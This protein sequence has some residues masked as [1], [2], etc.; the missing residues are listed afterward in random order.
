MSLEI[1]KLFSVCSDRL[2]QSHESYKNL[3]LIVDSAQHMRIKA[4]RSC[5]LYC[6]F[7]VRTADVFV[8]LLNDLLIDSS[9]HEYTRMHIH[10]FLS[11][12][13]LSRLFFS[14]LAAHGCGSLRKNADPQHVGINER[15]MCWQ[16]IVIYRLF[17]RTIYIP[18]IYTSIPIWPKW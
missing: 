6:T 18:R 3:P 1:R 17:M 4:L 12:R 13:I 16:L 11:Y 7:I 8:V 10:P 14:A 5:T 15:L 2:I 9:I